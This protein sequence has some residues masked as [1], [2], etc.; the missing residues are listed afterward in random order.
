MTLINYE[1]RLILIWS[2]N[3]AIFGATWDN[4]ICKT[5]TKFHVLVLTL[6]TQDNGKQMKSGFKTAII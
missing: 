5:D 2:A 4:I 3:C 6:S 1:T